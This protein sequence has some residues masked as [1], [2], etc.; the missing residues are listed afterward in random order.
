[1]QRQAQELL[2]HMG[3]EAQVEAHARADGDPQKLAENEALSQLRGRTKQRAH[4]RAVAVV[5]QLVAA[6]GRGEQEAEGCAVRTYLAWL[7]ATPRQ[8][9]ADFV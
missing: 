7:R 3:A 8:L 4:Q 6:I 9:V 1:M 5:A 2:P